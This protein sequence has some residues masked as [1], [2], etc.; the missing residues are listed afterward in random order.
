MRS[1]VLEVSG[2]R[3]AENSLVGP[4]CYQER[5][6][7]Q[8]TAKDTLVVPYCMCAI[9]ASVAGDTAKGKARKSLQIHDRK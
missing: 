2:S 3:R 4:R 1:R 8:H 9:P 7:K 6:K 5:L